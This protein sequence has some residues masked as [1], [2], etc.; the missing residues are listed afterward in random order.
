MSDRAPARPILV[1]NMPDWYKAL[2]SVVDRGPTSTRDV[3]KPA[4]VSAASANIRGEDVGGPL[5][6][7]VD[8]RFAEMCDVKPR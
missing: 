5:L 4:S 7:S 8:V 2:E 6:C 1:W 3:K